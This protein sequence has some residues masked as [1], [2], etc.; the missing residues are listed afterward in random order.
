[1]ADPGSGIA[2]KFH[3]GAGLYTYLVG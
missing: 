2:K 3:A 1:V